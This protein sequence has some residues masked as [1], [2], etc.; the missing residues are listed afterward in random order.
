MPDTPVGPD[1]VD[2]PEA[3]A[4]PKARWRLQIIWLIPLLAALIG[5]WL[6]LRAILERGPTVVIT[7]K[8]AEGLEAGKTK[9]K[10]KDVDIGLVKTITLS[11]DLRNIVVTAELIK[12]FKP[13][14]TE[15]TRFWIV[16]PRI[17]GGAV[18]G[19]GTLLG[20][21][22]V[23]VDVGRSTKAKNQF[24]GLETPP[25]VR[26]DAPGREYTLHA[27][28]VGSFDAGVPVFFR[29]LPVGQVVGYELNPDGNG[30]TV[31]VFINDPYT[32]FVNGNTRFWSAGG[33]KVRMDAG[34]VRVD[35]QSLAS[36]MIGGIAFD[37]PTAAQP[38]VVTDNTRF[39]LFSDREE[40]MKNPESDV[41]KMVMV[42]EESV[43]GLSVGAPVEFRGIGIGDVSAVNL[44]IDSA[45]GKVV[46]PVEVNLYPQ[47]L[48]SRSRDDRM[49]RSPEERKAVIDAMVA[50]G[51]RSQLRTG[52]LITGQLY[53]A[54][55]YL[56]NA[57]KAKM[58]WDA[59]PPEMPT[60][61]SNLQ[62]MQVALASVANKLD[63][64]PL[65]QIGANLEDTL[66]AANTLLTRFDTELTPQLRDT[67]SEA[68]KA[69]VS[70]DRLLSPNQGMQQ[71]MRAA[72]REMTR[73]ADSL[74][75]LA[76]YLERHPEALIR[77]KKGDEK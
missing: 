47:R 16:R 18:S 14:L 58:K 44:E 43:R 26:L 67:V 49:A 6:A 54:L 36:I 28:D 8:T 45:T 3:V 48:R 4:A 23:G 41:L 10:Y 70:A 20:G 56:P 40:A 34:G 62:E 69:I 50:H 9:L 60:A 27:D 32:K 19:I 1:I 63:R 59:D 57:P 2:F 22:Y 37:N 38:V 21:S 31:K 42:F 53:V 66:A 25:V 75:V 72:M 5:G 30:A 55:D 11:E 77:G 46:M 73:A 24:I 29:Q 33:I 64:L 12:D 15:D 61:K 35:T 68:R 74:R 39:M 51:M 7:F 52:N 76:D 13:H 71:D 65:E 17:S